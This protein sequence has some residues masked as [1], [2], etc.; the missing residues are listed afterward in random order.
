MRTADIVRN[1]AQVHFVSYRKGYAL[2][3]ADNGFEFPVP[4]EDVGDSTLNATESAMLLMKYIRAHL[5]VV[6]QAQD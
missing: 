1:G 3:K 5:K 6:E 2:Y 4:L